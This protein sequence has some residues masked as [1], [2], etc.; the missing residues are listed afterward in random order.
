MNIYIVSLFNNITFYIDILLFVYLFREILRD[1]TLRKVNNGIVLDIKQKQS[2]ELVALYLIF[3][4]W[5]NP[6]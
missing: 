2:Y 6:T 3:F 1:N 4:L 5:G